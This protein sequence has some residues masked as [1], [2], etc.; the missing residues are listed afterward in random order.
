MGTFT[1]ANINKLN[2]GLGR[3]T[4]SQDRII[5]LICGVTP[6]AG[7][8]VHKTVIECLDI[9]SIEALGI[10]AASD[11][12]NSELV[13]YHLDEMFRLCPGFTYYLLPVVKTTSIAAL[14]ADDD[15][16]AAVRGV[17]GRNVIGIA[18]IASATID[19]INT[20][21]LALQAWVNA[22][23]TEKILIDGVLLEGKAKAANADFHNAGVD[24]FD[25]R[26]L[27]APNITIVDMQDPAQAALNA[28]YATHGAV[29]T[30]LGSVAVRK[31]H[32]DLGSVDIESKPSAKKGNESFSIADSTLG[33]WTSAALSDGTL[34]SALSSAQQTSLSNKGY[35]YVGKFEQ[36]DGWYLSGCPTAVEAGSDYAF[37][38]FNCIWNKAARIIR[39]T[40]IPL[41][42]SKVP[43]E[44]D[45]TIKTT[46]VSSTQQ[47]VIDKLTVNMVNAGNADAV[48]VYI[49]PNQNVNAQTPMAVK[50]QVQVGDIVHEFDVDLGLTSKIS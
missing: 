39:T 6:I 24:I 44:L 50:A 30:V 49:N 2:G 37:F 10:T 29:G 45:G 17:A 22:F 25:M 21:A 38:N 26:S 18:G 12:N 13:H 15:I 48:D 5:V 47:K 4:D 43:K 33:K 14:V 42:R 19:V 31:V 1:G 20:D 36:Y 28:A 40:L 9:T 34:F 35:I 11:N 46:W 3:Y 41:V 32:E 7:K 27:A 16:K 23:A 8:V